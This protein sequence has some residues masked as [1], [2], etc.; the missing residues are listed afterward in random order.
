MKSF[1]LTVVCILT[2]AQVSY[3]GAAY[4]SKLKQG[5]CDLLSA[6]A[7]LFIHTSDRVSGTDDKLFGLFYGI[8]EGTDG[9]LSKSLSGVVNILTFPIENIE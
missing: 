9:I 8:A 7:E 3:A 1:I 4:D 5:V 2:L 6:P